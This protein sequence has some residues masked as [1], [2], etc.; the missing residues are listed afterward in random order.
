MYER[1]S[2]DGTGGEVKEHYVETW[3]NGDFVCA[4]PLDDEPEAEDGDPAVA[5]SLNDLDDFTRGYLVCALWA[6]NDEYDERG[7]NPLDE[8]YGLED[9]AP[10][11]LAQAVRECRDFQAAQAADLAEAYKLYNVTDGTSPEDYAG[12]DFWLTRNG[13]GAGFWDRGFGAVGDRLSK[14]TK[15][16]G[17]CSV[18]V[19][20]DNRLYFG[21]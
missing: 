15:P 14:A 19:G 16:Y 4:L 20:D 9:F 3:P 8:N 18:Y 2:I 11:A 12:H 5:V 17:S 1:M 10:E 13:H 6:E 21:G 7:G